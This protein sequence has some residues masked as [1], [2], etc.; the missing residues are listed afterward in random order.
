MP[1]L[2]LGSDL[3]EAIKNCEYY[4]VKNAVREE[5]DAIY[6][7]LAQFFDK[8]LSYINGAIYMEEISDI[9]YGKRPRKE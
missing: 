3:K 4:Q 2:G 1:K 7:A 6:N 8:R 9:I 5:Q